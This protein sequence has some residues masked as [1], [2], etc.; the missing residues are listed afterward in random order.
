MDIGADFPNYCEH[1]DSKPLAPRAFTSLCHTSPPD[2]SGRSSV[3]FAVQAKVTRER[4]NIGSESALG[5]WIAWARHK[6]DWIDP[7]VDTKPVL[8]DE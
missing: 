4:S 3:S 5:Q 1:G 2:M 8:D 7:L 6:A